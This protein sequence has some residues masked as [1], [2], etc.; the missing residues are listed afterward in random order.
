MSLDGT[1]P[2]TM[3]PEALR[4]VAKLAGGYGLDVFCVLHAGDGNLH[5]CFLYDGTDAEA[6]RKVE[7]AS[8]EVLRICA[9]LGGTVSGEH[10]IGIEK[11]A[12]M[13][14]VFSEDDLRAQRAVKSAF[15]PRGLCN[16]G[17]LL[18]PPRSAAVA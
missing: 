9:S 12:A 8:M 13:D 6:K 1:V 18:P 3:L 15:D 2:R 5:P 11:L 17:K 10:G 14:L 16:P 4:R 7:A